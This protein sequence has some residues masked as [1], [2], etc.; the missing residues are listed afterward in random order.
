[1][2][3]VSLYQKLHEFFS[4]STREF[5]Q[6]PV[7][8]IALLP[9]Q[10]NF[11]YE[12]S[13]HGWLR[14]DMGRFSR[15]ID[16]LEQQGVLQMGDLIQLSPVRLNREFGLSSGAIQKIEEALSKSELELDTHLGRVQT[17]IYRS[18]PKVR[19]WQY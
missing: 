11:I 5:G 19:G 7:R 6:G 1:M 8:V 9:K 3:G 17:E 4:V 15:S 14:R 16:K 2:V 18:G 13:L 10:Y 12:S